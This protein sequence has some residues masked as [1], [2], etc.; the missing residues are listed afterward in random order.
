MP[1]Y[2]GHGGSEIDYFDSGSF[3][4]DTLSNED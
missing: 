3:Y 2:K 4:I 1:P